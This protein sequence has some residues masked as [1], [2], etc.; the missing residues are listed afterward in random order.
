ME[1]KNSKSYGNIVNAYKGEVA[2]ELLYIFL[3]EKLLNEGNEELGKVFKQLSVEEKGHVNVLKKYLKEDAENHKISEKE[4][5]ALKDKSHEDI[6]KHLEMFSAGEKK[7]GEEIYPMFAKVASE[8]GFG[9]IAK[10]FNELAKV[11]LKHGI[12]LGEELKKL[13]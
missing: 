3:S 9:D 4:I 7:A 11:E 2:G 5:E 8:E 13:K 6:V 1:F 12:L 10:M